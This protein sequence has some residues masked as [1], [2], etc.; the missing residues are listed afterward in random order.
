MGFLQGSLRRDQAAGQ[1]AKKQKDDTFWSQLNDYGAD[2]SVNV[3]LAQVMNAHQLQREHVGCW[4]CDLIPWSSHSHAQQ[5]SFRCTYAQQA[6][7]QDW[8]LK[9]QVTNSSA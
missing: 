4:A 9:Q 5:Q 1:D 6:Q 7:D 2:T 3:A 8:L